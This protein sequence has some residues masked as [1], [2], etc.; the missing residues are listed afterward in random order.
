MSLNLH[1]DVPASQI[2]SEIFDTL[3]RLEEIGQRL[4]HC[5]ERYKIYTSGHSLT[6]PL[7]ISLVDF[8]AHIIQFSVTVSQIY[9]RRKFSALFLLLA[10]QEL[11]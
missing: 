4:K 6:G 9:R 2:A 7:R 8:Y 10:G 11:Y 1:F 3:D 5:L